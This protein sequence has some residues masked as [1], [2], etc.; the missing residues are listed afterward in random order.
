MALKV[1]ILMDTMI[2]EV[3]QTALLSKQDTSYD[4]FK[5]ELAAMKTAMAAL[6]TSK[7]NRRPDSRSR[8]RGSRPAQTS[9]GALTAA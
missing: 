4:E 6:Q 1:T 7:L 2:N 8:P 3:Q 9:C 5:T